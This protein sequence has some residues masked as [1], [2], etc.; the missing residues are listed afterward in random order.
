MSAQRVVEI[1]GRRVEI[2]DAKRAAVIEE[3]PEI[4]WIADD[5]LRR[6]VTD[7][8]VAALGASSFARVGEMKASG[9]ADT[10]PLKEGTQADH[11]R[12]VTRLALKI[13]E[14]MAA[15]FTSFAYDRDLLIAGCLCHD[16]GKPWEFDP[17][18][19]RRWEADPRKVGCPSIRH[20]AF[21]AHICLTMGLPEAV[22]HMAT[23]HSGEGELLT[24]S[25]E[26]S[27][28]HRADYDFWRIAEA[29]GLMAGDG[30]RN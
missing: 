10:V 5:R 9:N 27:I 28:L 19:R 29:G 6:G 16:I 14:E 25:L 26:N 2:T 12:S 22:A 1:Y 24:R 15:T 30:G 23:A 3:M 13:A 18:N 21:G 7:A 20:P 11:I 4:G 17:E 8:W